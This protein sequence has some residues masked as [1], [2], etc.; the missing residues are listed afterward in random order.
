VNSSAIRGVGSVMRGLLGLVL[1]F[2][3]V[4]AC[5]GGAPP[6]RLSRAAK[7]GPA[8][9]G[10]VKPAV[11]LTIADLEHAGATTTKISDTETLLCGKSGCMCMKELDCAGDECITLAEN[12]DVFR[13]ALA[14]DTHRVYCEL[15]D[16]GRFCDLS[17]FR[18]EGDIYR[19]EV[20][21]F[22][23]DGRLVGQSNATDYD[24]YCE[25]KAT[26]QFMG[27]LPDC[28]MQPRDVELI[29]SQPEY[30]A[31]AGRLANPRELA[32]E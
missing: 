10:P 17:Y 11:L 2:V 14:R 18:F 3:F 19:W 9:T 8:N 23:T 6:A 5:G 22:G 12:L 31:T 7:P 32:L 30:R 4:A 24:E 27:R 26:R 25:G 13:K 28:A 16:T 21:Y 15:A 1:A 29:C 20:R